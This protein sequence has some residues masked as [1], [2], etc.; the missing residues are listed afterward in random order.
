MYVC[1]Y[2]LHFFG[3]NHGIK[4][5]HQCK[6]N[7]ILTEDSVYTVI[8]KPQYPLFVHQL[9]CITRMSVLENE[10][11]EHSTS[12][13]CKEVINTRVG[14]LGDKPGSGKSYTI[15]AHIEN[16]PILNMTIDR[17]QSIMFPLAGFMTVTNK[18]TYD[19]VLKTNL[20]IVPKGIHRQWIDY[21]AK[22][23]PNLSCFSCINTV[24]SMYNKIYSGDYDIV[25][26]SDLQYK[27]LCD[28]DG[29]YITHKF[30]RAIIDDA[31]IISIT[32]FKMPESNF[33]WL[34]SSTYDRILCG[35][36]KTYGLSCFGVRKKTL[37][38]I[39]CV[40]VQSSDAFIE[41]SIILPSVQYT[42]IQ[43]KCPY[44]VLRGIFP[45]NAMSLLDANDIDGAIHVLRCSSVATDD[46]LVAA[47][48][49]KID[50][51]VDCML[52][53][54]PFAP[55]ESI[56]IINERIKAEKMKKIDCLKRVLENNICPIGLSDICTKAV[57]PCCN[58]AFEFANIVQALTLTSKCPMCRASVTPQDL[59]V[60][61]Q[62]DTPH[63]HEHT[64]D[65]KLIEVLGEVFA[66][67]EQPRIIV[68]SMHNTSK[69]ESVISRVYPLG[70]IGGSM[71]NLST[72]I[73]K[74]QKGDVKILML[75]TNH[76]GAGINMP[77]VTHIVTLHAMS[78]DTMMQLVG[79]A[80]RPGRKDALTVVNITYIG[81]TL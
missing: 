47:F 10:D 33:L 51:K 48:I 26:L 69:F 49:A 36:V 76:L 19:K 56:P 31:D 21:I 65:S 79:R 6:V 25:L 1:L 66:S 24:D 50:S 72:I 29:R 40:I 3:K 27:R 32:G 61:V 5:R 63:E 57:T 55:V 4:R 70:K 53:A 11:F 9:A 28:R 39:D 45:G 16:R 52:T 77:F 18:E 17:I 8:D 30:Q 74:F 73:E 22:F 54:I 13:A 2:S 38:L 43:L 7:M 58:N 44:N 42:T 37:P 59:I 15:L 75:D 35:N 46:G 60:K 80:Q 41:K 81:E 62:S 23:A 67:D 12:A 64:K 14:I 68:C 71:K 20:I 34:I 78:K